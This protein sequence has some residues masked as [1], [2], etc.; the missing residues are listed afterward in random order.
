MS[1]TL[2]DARLIATLAHRGD[3]YGDR[4]YTYHLHAVE[5]TLREF[6]HTD[7]HLLKGAWLHDVIEDTAWTC[8]R[9]ER[10][11]EREV[12]EVVWRVTDEPGYD[13]RTQAKQATYPKIAAS[14]DATT[15]KLAD[16]LANVRSCRAD[17]RNGLLSMYR[18]E[19]DAFYEALYTPRRDPMWSALHAVLD[20]YPSE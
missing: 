20:W 16:R 7:D 10:R 4:S 6:D 19:H 1:A 5:Q 2:D 15:L 9:L 12:V 18:R 8:D 3:Q 14:L 11:F 17:G 13:N